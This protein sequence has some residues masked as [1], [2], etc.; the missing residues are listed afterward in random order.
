M[1]KAILFDLD[2]TLLPMD[3]EAFT[4]AY[5][6][7]LANFMK[8]LGFDGKQLVETIVQGTLD[9]V[10]N[11]GKHTNETV[12]WHSFQNVYGVEKSEQA[13]VRMELF[14]GEC[15][16][17]TKQFC[18]YQPLARKAIDTARE[19]GARIVLATNPI[20]PKVATAARIQWA[21]LDPK[22]FDLYTTYETSYF[23]KPNPRYYQSIADQL[24]VEARE[25]MMI[26]NDVGE[27][28]IAQSIDMKT[29]L[30]TD[31]LINQTNA[32]ITQYSKGSFQVLLDEL[33]R[34]TKTA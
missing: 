8:P 17:E 10:K 1:I 24:G 16:H 4:K 22:D 12:F 5:F 9:M 13:K 19:T 30:L 25:C 34:L 28:M 27:D 2:G 33:K 29:F 32:D 14:Y 3:Q 23:C 18:A 31:C 7:H 11:D 15:F 20:F 26:G 6:H 21:G